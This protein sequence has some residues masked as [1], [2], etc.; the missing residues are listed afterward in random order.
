[1][2]G[3]KC[4]ELADGIVVIVQHSCTGE[5]PLLFFDNNT[6]E[7]KLVEAQVN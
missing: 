6:L 5:V 4:K 1:M 3:A 7:T 2:N